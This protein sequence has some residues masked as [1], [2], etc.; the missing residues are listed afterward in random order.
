[1]EKTYLPTAEEKTA[2][3]RVKEAMRGLSQDEARGRLNASKPAPTVTA[4]KGGWNMPYDQINTL[5]AELREAGMLESVCG[6]LSGEHVH[7]GEW[8][9][10][11]SRYEQTLA[12][13]PQDLRR[14]LM[15][16]IPRSSP[17]PL[18]RERG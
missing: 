15:E 1:M 16:E 13:L 12:N 5:A 6:C 10:C 4:P 2:V 8:W 3:R 18:P 9:R 11:Y 14:Q 17:S 7:S